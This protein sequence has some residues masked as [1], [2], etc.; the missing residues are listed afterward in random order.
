[1]WLQEHG[2]DR[3]FPSI[4]NLVTPFF[5]S[6]QVA[7]TAFGDQSKR[8][9]KLMHKAFG[10]QSIPAY[11]PLIE[12]ENRSF[13]RRLVTTPTNYADHTRRYAGGLTL[14]VVYGYEPKSHE[15]KFLALAEEC[16][17]LLSNHIA[18]GGGLWPV[19]I[20]PS[21]QYLPDWFPGTGFKHKAAI[22]KAKMEE[23]V[24]KPYEFV[25]N[26]IVRPGVSL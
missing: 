13:L 26:S 4:P 1:M 18:S 15:D 25:K 2:K 14:S 10:L 20:F 3:P 6:E 17:D 16:V 19:D 8:Q 7:F 9:R 22:W 21:L 11:N 24:N 12:T 5:W 23:F